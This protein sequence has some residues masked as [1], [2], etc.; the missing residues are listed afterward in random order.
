MV[1]H[2][3]GRPD[4]FARILIRPLPP[5]EPSFILWGRNQLERELKVERAAAGRAAVKARGKSGGRPKTDQAIL[6]RARSTGKPELRDRSSH[7][8]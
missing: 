6:E 7:L 3:A 4:L 8:F 1:V 5:A 2:L